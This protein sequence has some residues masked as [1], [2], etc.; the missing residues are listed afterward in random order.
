[1]KGLEDSVNRGLGLL[2][3]GLGVFFMG[4]S[5]AGVELI[6]DLPKALVFS[7]LLSDLRQKR[8]ILLGLNG[9]TIS[10]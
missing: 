3:R 9:N 2:L 4:W 10:A 7:N 8:H 6:S 5:K 1:M